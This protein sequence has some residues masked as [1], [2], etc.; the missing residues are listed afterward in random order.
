MSDQEAKN[1]TSSD[2]LT[3]AAASDNNDANA[4]S[5]SANTIPENEPE[6]ENEDNDDEDDN[7]DDDLDSEYDLLDNV[8]KE[9]MMHFYTSPLNKDEIISNVFQ[10]NKTQDAKKIMEDIES[11]LFFITNASSSKDQEVYR[12]SKKKISIQGE[13]LYNKN[14][15]IY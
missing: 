13:N 1:D 4:T 14:K 8:S 3:K 10:I 5:G 6:N 15:K 2:D 11:G 12:K 7:E 9:I